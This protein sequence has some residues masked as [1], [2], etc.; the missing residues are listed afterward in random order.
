MSKKFVT[1]AFIS[2]LLIP[3]CVNAA[4]SPWASADQLRA[5]MITVPDDIG[6]EKI[7]EGGIEVELTQGW[8][9][10]WKVPGDAGLPPTFAWDDAQNVES[11]EI[12]FPVPERKDEAG[13]QVFGYTDHVFL[14]FK[15]ALVDPAKPVKLNLDMQM[16][17]CHEICVPQTVKLELDVPNSGAEKLN[18][19]HKSLL[20]MEKRKLPAAEETSSLKPLTVVIGKDALAVGVMSKSGFENIDMTAY[21]DGLYFTVKPKVEI[22]ATDKKTAILS[23]PKPEGVEDLNAAL[24]GKTLTILVR[25]GREAVEK[26]MQF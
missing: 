13:L 8:H 11:V 14:P 10:Y 17:V 21:S 16:M 24:A 25:N 15:V 4:Q 20:E 6:G 2:A 18:P 19:A 1:L 9:T 22:D 26:E 23:I 5:R 12:L 3:V 7:F